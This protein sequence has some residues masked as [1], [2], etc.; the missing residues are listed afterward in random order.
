MLNTPDNLVHIEAQSAANN[1]VSAFRELQAKTKMVESERTSAV[2]VRD[3]LRQELAE[4][5]RKHGLCRNKDEVRSNNHLQ[6]IKASTDEQLVGYNY[7]RSLFQE[8]EDIQQTQN[9][10]VSELTNTQSQLTGEIEQLNSKI[11]AAEHRLRGLREDLILSRE[12][13]NS[14]EKVGLVC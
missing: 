3:E 11:L 12:Q 8:Q 10:K 1:V 13:S 4:I 2:V 7:T 5:R 14:M 9:H 6:S